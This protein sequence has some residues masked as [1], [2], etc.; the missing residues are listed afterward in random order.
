MV[1]KLDFDVWLKDRYERIPGDIE[2]YTKYS[3]KKEFNVDQ[4]INEYLEYF[5]TRTNEEKIWEDADIKEDEITK[6]IFA[7]DEEIIG[8]LDTGEAP[9]PMVIGK[10][11]NHNI[12]AFYDSSCIPKNPDEEDIHPIIYD[13]LN[14]WLDTYEDIINWNEGNE[15]DFWECF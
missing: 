15:D 14:E 5:N 9:H 1:K 7:F 6:I 8:E 2:K 12:C 4:V 11:M 13:I 10:I 3:D